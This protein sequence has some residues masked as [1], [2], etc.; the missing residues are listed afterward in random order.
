MM[1]LRRD[2]EEIYRK[3]LAEARNQIEEIDIQIEDQ[4]KSIKARLQELQTS[5][6]AML[7]VCK[8][9][10]KILGEDG[11]EEDTSTAASAT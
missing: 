6:K 11:A 2:Q 7:E 10:S 4:I 1:D 3:T 8:S 5:K 9:L